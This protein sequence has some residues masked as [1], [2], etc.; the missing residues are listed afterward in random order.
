MAGYAKMDLI[1]ILSLLTCIT[2]A[3]FAKMRR[4]IRIVPVEKSPA[5]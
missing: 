3:F 2:A 4:N 5:G 1:Y